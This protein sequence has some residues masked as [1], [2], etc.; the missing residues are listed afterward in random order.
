[1]N[2]TMA[3]PKFSAQVLREFLNYDPSTGI[4]TWI[5]RSPRGRNRVG[6]VAGS[7]VQG[8]INIGIFNESYGAHCLAWLYVNGNW[9]EGHIDHIDG[10]G[11]N[12]RF[13]NL[14]K[15]SSAENQQNRKQARRDSGTG[16]IGVFRSP[17]ARR[18]FR[19]SITICGK[20]HHLGVF[21]SAEEA[22]AA[23]L[24]A[25]RSLHPFGNL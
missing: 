5:K 10:N 9:P 15:A 20:A 7:I 23:Y 3:K 21:Q 19:S 18:P 1:M 17:S 14:R 24:A 6:T 4:F 12:N 22:H 8:Y 25:K 2:R 13:A 16:L 11:M